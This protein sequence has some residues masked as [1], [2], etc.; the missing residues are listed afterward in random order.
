[1]K[2]TIISILT[3]ILIYMITP[4]IYFFIN[5]T[6]N[7]DFLTISSAEYNRLRITQGITQGIQAR[8][9]EVDREKVGETVMTTNK[10]NEKINGKSSQN[11]SQ[12]VNNRMN[13][14]IY[15]EEIKRNG[16]KLSVISTNKNSNKNTVKY[17]SNNGHNTFSQGVEKRKEKEVNGKPEMNSLLSLYGNRTKQQYG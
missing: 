16:Q 3:L 14:I 4:I 1:M 2:T 5:Q 10:S 9:R 17:S 12:S 15:Q 13:E 7:A 8:D 11:V 6:V